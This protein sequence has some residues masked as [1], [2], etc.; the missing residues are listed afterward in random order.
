MSDEILTAAITDSRGEKLL[1]ALGSQDLSL[2]GVAEL[3]ALR[4]ALQAEV[5]R[6]EAALAGRSSAT[7][8]AEA[9]F[10]S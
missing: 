10:K 6:V 4:S 5:K 2:L 3:E 1:D 9:L 8:A 7:A